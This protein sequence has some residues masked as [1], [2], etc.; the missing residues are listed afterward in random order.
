MVARIEAARSGMD[1]A[2]HHTS[3]SCAVTAEHLLDFA[4]MAGIEFLLIDERLAW[5]SS[6]EA[7]EW[8]YYLLSKGL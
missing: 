3:F 7:M 5:K 2:A 8:L 4:E 6:R 1:F